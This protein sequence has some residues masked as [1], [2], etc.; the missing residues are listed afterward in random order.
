VARDRPELLE[1]I[2]AQVAE[3]LSVWQ[4]NQVAV[5]A[6]NWQTLQ[7]LQETLQ[8][9]GIAVRLGKEA[10]K[11]VWEL[12]LSE[13]TVK[14]LTIHG[15]KGLDFPCVFLAGLAPHDLGGPSRAHLAETRRQLYVALTR[16][17]CALTVALVDG[18]HHPLLDLLDDR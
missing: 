2:R 16:S 18:D 11:P 17:S 14:L 12:P 13:P 3:A 7:A 8:A 1:G 6:G 15:A 9:A 10:E 5:L 4:P